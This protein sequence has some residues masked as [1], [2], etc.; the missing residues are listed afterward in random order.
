MDPVQYNR[1]KE[2]FKYRRLYFSLVWFHA[3]LLERKKFR[4]L[5]WNSAY[6]FSDSDFDMCENILAMY[7]DE[8]PNEVQ[9][10]AIKYLIAEANYGGRVTQAP[11]NRVLRAYLYFFFFLPHFHKLYF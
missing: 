4:T 8:Y 10:E 3:I 2:T 7:L 11:D 9:W 6:D 1:V 5:G